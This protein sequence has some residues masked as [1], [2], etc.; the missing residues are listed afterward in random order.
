MLAVS[1]SIN[2]VVSAD[3]K[4]QQKAVRLKGKGA[5]TTAA[6]PC[7]L[8]RLVFNDAV[9]TGCFVAFVVLFAFFRLVCLPFLARATLLLGP[10]YRTFTLSHWIMVLFLHV[11][12]QG[13][14]V[15]WFALIVKLAI[16]IFTGGP[17]AD[18]RSDNDTEEDDDI[19]S[20]AGNAVT[21]KNVNEAG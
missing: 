7:L 5:G 6:A 4:R 16:H 3:T 18:I 15:Y 19:Y 9:V 10:K 14:H 8:Y 1:K 20:S 12:L 21:L 2:Y 11:V 17:C 13:L